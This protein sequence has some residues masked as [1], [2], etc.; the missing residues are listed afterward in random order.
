MATEKKVVKASDIATEE[1]KKAIKE[2]EKTKKTARKS[3]DAPVFV[4][5]AEAKNKATMLRIISIILWAGAITCEAI[6]I[7]KVLHNWATDPNMVLMIILIL[8]DVALCI[9]ANLLWKKAN[10]LDPAS[11]KN[12]VKFFVQNQLGLI[13]SIIAFLPLIILI[14]TNKDMDG[15]QKGIVGVIAIVA[16]IAAGATGLS[17]NPP[18]AEQYAEQTSTVEALTGQN[19]VYWTQHGTKYHLYDSCQHIN[20]DATEQIFTGTVAEARELKNISE[21]CITCENKAKAA[22]PDADVP[23]GSVEDA[24]DDATADT[25]DDSADVA[26]DTEDTGEEDQAA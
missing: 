12:G 25:T 14:F 3:A 8:A 23:D 5:T 24:T 7:F 18:S 13:L 11:E 1:Q 16:L 4:P 21:L 22:M 2:S 17:L 9:V 26:D 6:A 19:V 15:K 20:T 10:R